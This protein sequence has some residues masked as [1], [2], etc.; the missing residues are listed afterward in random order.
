MVT[1]CSWRIASLHR[2]CGSWPALRA[3][4]FQIEKLQLTKDWR[5]R[6]RIVDDALIRRLSADMA[7]PKDEMAEAWRLICASK[8]RL[9]MSA[10][11]THLAREWHWFAGCSIGTWLREELPFVQ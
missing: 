1:C 2:C 6:F 8:G 9:P 5:N 10:V 4:G 3:I 7:G 11:A